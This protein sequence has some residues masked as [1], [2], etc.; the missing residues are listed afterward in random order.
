MDG[1][2]VE[3]G[4]GVGGGKSEVRYRNNCSATPSVGESVLTPPQVCPI[5]L[6]KLMW[7]KL[8]GRRKGSNDVRMYHGKSIRVLRDGSNMR[9]ALLCNILVPVGRGRYHGAP[10][11]ETGTSC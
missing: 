11:V 9:L 5:S 10:R 6:I 1:S 4:Q 2:I 7:K 8:T 3:S